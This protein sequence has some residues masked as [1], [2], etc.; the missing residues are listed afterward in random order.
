MSAKDAAYGDLMR[1]REILKSH[2]GIEEDARQKLFT[3]IDKCTANLPEGSC[4]SAEMVLAVHIMRDVY[5]EAVKGL[6]QTNC[7]Q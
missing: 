1:V 2:K 5:L 3:K 7:L 4:G 6:M